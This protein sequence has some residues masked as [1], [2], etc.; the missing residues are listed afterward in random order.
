LRVGGLQGATGYVAAI[1]GKLIATEVRV[2]VIASWPDY[3]FKKGYKLMPIE[4][5]AAKISTE[6]HLPGV[7]SAADMKENGIMLG[8]MQTKTMEKVEENT[9]YII[10]L[11]NKIKLLEKK[12]DELTKERK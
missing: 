6:S 2:E 12:I 4:D 5:L 10:E 8:E 1:N 3:V 9:L 7:P 11:N